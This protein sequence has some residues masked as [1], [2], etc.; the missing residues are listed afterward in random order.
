MTKRKIL[1][2]YC[3]RAEEGMLTPVMKRIEK[4]KEMQLLKVDLRKENLKNINISSLGEIY[5]FMIQY[6]KIQ[7]PDIAIVG[8][9]RLEMI[10]STLAIFHN[11]IHPIVHLYAG[12]CDPDAPIFDEAHRYAISV[13]SDMHF[14]TNENACNRMIELR[15]IM[16]KDLKHIY[17][18]S[19]TNL[20]D[21]EFDNA[22]VPKDKNYDLV[23]LHPCTQKL[24]LVPEDILMTIREIMKRKDNKI[25]F[26]NPN[27][28]LG[29]DI[30]DNE[31]E[32]TAQIKPDRVIY[33]PKGISRPQFLALLRECDRFISNSS[34]TIYEAP[35][36]LEPEQIVHIGLRNRHRDRLSRDEL[37]Q[38]GSDLIVKVLKEVKL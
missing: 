36:F 17:K 13:Y 5:N 37:T 19:P 33:Y 23:L 26:L 11:N 35:Y 20:D 7:K 12:D 31:W 10:F 21:L 24:G 15:N 27:G 9:D 6:T 30:I 28:D 3:N 34:A 32:S 22:L 2:V 1:V 29:S 38:G 16:G 18:I 14:C 25:I 8:Y 4:D